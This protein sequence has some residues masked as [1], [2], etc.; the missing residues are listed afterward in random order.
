MSDNKKK[1]FAFIDSQNLNLGIL[2]QGW[3]LDWKR[4]RVY[5]QEKYQVQ[6]AYLFLGFMPANKK[7]YDFLKNCGYQIIF[8]PVITIKGREI[9]GNVDAELVLQSSAIDFNI[10]DKAI[11]ISGDGDFYCLVKYL[12]KHSKLERILVPNKFSYSVLLRRAIG[13]IGYIAFFNDLRKLL[14]YK[15]STNESGAFGGST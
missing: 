9:K 11:L 4:L 12:L 15:S 1:N 14:E 13:P 5:L 6:T 3:K 7:L 8:K 10:Y 2:N